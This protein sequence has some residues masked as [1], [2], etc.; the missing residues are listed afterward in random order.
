MHDTKSLN[1]AHKKAVHKNFKTFQKVVNQKL[2][3]RGLLFFID[4]STYIL[5]ESRSLKTFLKE[6]Y[7]VT[8]GVLLHIYQ[9][10]VTQ[11]TE[12]DFDSA[13]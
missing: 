5:T 13:Y 2:P 4:I 9:E 7:A 10:D 1:K 3:S 11:G 6:N 12:H 8:F